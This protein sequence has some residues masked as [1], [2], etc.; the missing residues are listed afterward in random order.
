MS[1]NIKTILTIV[2]CL[3]FVVLLGLTV[4]RTVLLVNNYDLT[5]KQFDIGSTNL[6]HLILIL[7]FAVAIILF[8]SS[9]I[10]K[11]HEVKEFKISSITKMVSSVLLVGSTISN[12]VYLVN[13]DPNNYSTSNTF[14]SYKL[15]LILWSIF[16]LL[17]VVYLVYSIVQKDKDLGALS[18]VLPL[19][20]GMGILSS[21]FN[22]DCSLMDNNKTIFCFI[23]MSAAIMFIKASKNKVYEENNYLT[24]LLSSVLSVGLSVLFLIPNIIYVISTKSPIT[25]WGM[26]NLCALF[27]LIYS[28]NVM[29]VCLKNEKT[30]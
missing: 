11:K 21:Y 3:T 25:L 20:A 30:N 19:W 9:F 18:I 4:L 12:A 5:T 23:L 8:V 13:S 2:F 24:T 15:L 22:P 26:E 27:I 16:A 1:K 17:S 7:S 14:S 10:V 6:T 28:I 29:I